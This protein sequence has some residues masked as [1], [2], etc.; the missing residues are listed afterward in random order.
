MNKFKKVINYNKAQI[1][2]IKQIK[3]I[4]IQYNK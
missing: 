1:R 2:M 3:N 4:M